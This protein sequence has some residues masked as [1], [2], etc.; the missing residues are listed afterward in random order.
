MSPV[1]PPRRDR[2]R[3]HLALL[4]LRARAGWLR[5]AAAGLA[6]TT[7]WLVATDL[8]ALHRRAGNLGPERDVVVAARDLALGATVGADD[9]AETRRHTSQV[10]GRALEDAGAAIGSTVVVPVIA[11]TTLFSEHLADTDRDWTAAVVPADMRALRVPDPN[12]LDPS[13]GDLVDV[14]VA[15]DPILAE[16]TQQATAVPV[17]AAQVLASETETESP[18]T[19]TGGA[20]RTGSVL[21]LVPV[22]EVE[23]LAFAVANGTVTLALAPPEDACCATSSSASSKD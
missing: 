18:L 11:G 21:V 2:S 14:I 3:L 19:P 4:S 20:D 6:V 15:V 17:A 13:P 7:A 1:N 9:L 12:G 16:Q 23:R 8:A 10:S 22:A 5:L